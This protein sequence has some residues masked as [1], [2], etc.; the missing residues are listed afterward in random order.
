MDVA[1]LLMSS[2]HAGFGKPRTTATHQISPGLIGSVS[3]C[4]LIILGLAF[5]SFLGENLVKSQVLRRVSSLRGQSRA[6]L[7]FHF[8]PKTAEK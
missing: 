5:L 1:E 7:F 4:T 6:S 2:H 3:D 8:N